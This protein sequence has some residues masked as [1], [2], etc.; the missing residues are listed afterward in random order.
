MSLAL[1][2]GACAFADFMARLRMDMFSRQFAIM[3]ERKIRDMTVID[4]IHGQYWVVIAYV[5][6]F[7][8]CL[9]WLE[10]RAASRWTVCVAFIVLALPALAYGRACLHIGS[11]VI[12]WAT[13]E[14]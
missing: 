10:I 11:K 12:L 8:A 6:V 1:R 14:G 2:L 7:L 9:L 3:D 4:F 13:T 5:A